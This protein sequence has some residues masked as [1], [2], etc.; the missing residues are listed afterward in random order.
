MARKPQSPA[1][2]GIPPSSPAASVT[3]EEFERQF[4]AAV[5]RGRALD[6]AEPRAAEAYYDRSTGRIILELR[7]GCVFGFPAEAEESLRGAT[8]EQLAGVEVVGGEGLHWEELDADISVPGLIAHY[9]NLRAW[10]SRYLGQ[11]TSAAKARA[12][13]ANGRKGGRPRKRRAEAASE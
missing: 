10:A 1:L 3:D 6:A 8:P 9:I 7:N 12:A 13:R 11:C 5:I 2:P 4:Q